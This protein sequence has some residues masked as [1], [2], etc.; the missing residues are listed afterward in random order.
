MQ[1]IDCIKPRLAA[2]VDQVFKIPTDNVRN[3]MGD[4]DGDMP[5]II[6]IFGRDH[7]LFHIKLGQFVSFVRQRQ[8]VGGIECLR[9]KR[10]YTLWGGL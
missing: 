5:G 9:K 2:H 6:D 7:F 1:H 10:F 8:Q 3:C 4:S